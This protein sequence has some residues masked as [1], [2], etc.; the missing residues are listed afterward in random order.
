MRLQNSNLSLG[1]F[2]KVFSPIKKELY[3]K[4]GDVDALRDEYVQEEM[5]ARNMMEAARKRA[6]EEA[7]SEKKRLKEFEL[8]TDEEMDEAYF[9]AMEE[10]NEARMR[11]IIHE[12]ARRNG[13]VSA[14]EFRMAHRAPS[15]D[16]ESKW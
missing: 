9:K 3:E 1:Q 13:Y 10:N 7:E 11:D 12:S 2:V 4:F 8:M 6:E 5:K 14:D 15:Y 16:E